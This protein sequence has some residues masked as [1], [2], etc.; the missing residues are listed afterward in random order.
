[1]LY[2]IIFFGVLWGLITLFSF[3]E[4][5]KYIKELCKSARKA[6]QPYHGSE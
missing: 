6:T 1:M 3:R 4:E 5:D 2:V